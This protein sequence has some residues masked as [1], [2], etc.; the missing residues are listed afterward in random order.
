MAVCAESR[1]AVMERDERWAAVTE[2]VCD[3]NHAAA[4]AAAEPRGTSSTLDRI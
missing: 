4:D 2:T 3:V 1:R